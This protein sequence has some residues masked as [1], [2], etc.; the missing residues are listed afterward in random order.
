MI[1][2][3]VMWR[4]VDKN[5]VSEAR[6]RLEKM[7]GRVPSMTALETGVDFKGGPAAYDLVLITTHPDRAALDAYQ[8]DAFHIGVKSF[9]GGLD[10]DRAVVDFEC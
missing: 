7:R 5:A 8:N 9:L 4:F 3:V 10:C 1:K 2:H 6:R